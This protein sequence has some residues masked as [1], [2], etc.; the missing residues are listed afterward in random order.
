LKKPGYHI[1][2]S[3]ENQALASSEATEFSLH[4]P[5]KRREALVDVLRLLQAVAR[6]LGAAH[7]LRP[8]QVRNVAPQLAK[9]KKINFEKPGYHHISGGS[10]VGNQDITFLVV[11][12]LETR[13]F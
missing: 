8:R 13:R 1:S 4:S 7:A 12:G 11:Q 6:R 5:A 3:L 10:R 2:G 9:L